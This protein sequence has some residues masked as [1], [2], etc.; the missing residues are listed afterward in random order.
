VLSEQPQD[1]GII[2][3]PV[4]S[5]GTEF[6]FSA[7]RNTWLAL[8]ATLFCFAF[9]GFIGYCLSVKVELVFLAVFII[10]DL[11]LLVSALLQWL[12]TSK[13]IIRAGR[14]EVHKGI[15][16]LGTTREIPFTQIESI[17]MPIGSYEER[18]S[19]TAYYDLKLQLN[20]GEQV[21]LA[22]AIRKK[23]EVEWLIARMKS[24]IGLNP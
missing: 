24:E 20:T 9:T 4:E 12:G 7:G 15:L 10:L 11:V 5:G 2:V 1:A 18:S 14:L 6:K 22:N 17:I 23:R 16:E 3:R 8:R 21:V 13:V 19:N